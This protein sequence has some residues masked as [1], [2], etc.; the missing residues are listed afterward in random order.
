MALQRKPKYL[1]ANEA[2]FRF[3]GH[4]SQSDASSAG[5]LNAA[6]IS[7]QLQP[8][9]L[10]ICQMEPD[11]RFPAGCFLLKGPSAFYSMPE[12]RAVKDSLAQMKSANLFRTQRFPRRMN[13]NQ[14]CW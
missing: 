12:G 6:S 7:L 14:N 4:I 3:E 1:P 11:S 13:Q 8:A 10:R 2:K 5:D 9:M